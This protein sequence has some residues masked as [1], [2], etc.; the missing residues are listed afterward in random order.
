MKAYSLFFSLSILL[1]S[2]CSLPRPAL[3]PTPSIGSTMT[4][5]IDGMTLVYV[6]AGKFTMGSI[7]EASMVIC[8]NFNLNCSP[9]WFTNQEP[10][11]IVYLDAFWIDKTEVTNGMYAAC[12]QA[13]KCNASTSTKSYT[14][15][16]YYGNSQFDNFPVLFVTWENAKDYC[17][18]ADRRL[19][20]EA[21]WEKAARGDDA[22]LFPWGND[23]PSDDLLN[24]RHARLDT[25]A[26][27]NIPKDVSPYGALD[28][29]GNVW[30][31]VADWY[32]ETYY[33]SS[34]MS[35]PLGPDAGTKK[36]VRG[37]AFGS[38][39]YNV[40]ST[41]RFISSPQETYAWFGFRCA[42]SAAR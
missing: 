11:H 8:E 1:L 39:T 4:S 42:M 14:H 27:G 36:V 16:D 13:G 41:F 6:P 15:D 37:G 18:W 17:V 22:R 20:T 30:E 26:V 2:S 32:G 40:T 38:G 35:N 5:R 23:L 28:M 7:A 12:V 21:E 3:T 25:I 10:P 24:F 34:P 29:A 9:D 19:P 33:A 31:W